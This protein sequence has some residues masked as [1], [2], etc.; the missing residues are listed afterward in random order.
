MSVWDRLGRSLFV[1]CAVGLAWGIRGDFGHMLGAAYPGA[2]L[3][4]AFAYVTGQRSMFRWM[5]IVSAAS[6]LAISQGGRMSYGVLHGYAQADT[7]INYAY[8]LFCLVLEGGAWGCFGGAAIGLLLEPERERLRPVD[9]LGL[10]GT[11]LAFGWATYHVVV[12]LLGFHINPYRSDLS[13]GYTGGVVGLFVWLANHR[14]YYGLRGAASAFLG[15]GLGMAFSRFLA[16]ATH[17]Q[18]YTINHW[19]VMEVGTGFFGGLVFTYSMLGKR[20]DDPPAAEWQ[21]TLSKLSIPFVMAGIPLYH[22]LTRVDVKKKA[23]ELKTQAQAWG[24]GDPAEFARQNVEYLRWVCLL[25]FAGAVVWLYIHARDK[26]R[27]SAFPVLFFSA[28][29]LL[30][31]NVNAYYFWYDRKPNTINMHNVFW[32]LF[33]LMVLYSAVWSK[34]DVTDPDAEADRVPW[35]RWVVG[36]LVAYALTVALTGLVNGERSMKSANTR[37]PIWAWT[38]GPYTG[39]AYGGNPDRR[40]GRRAEGKDKEAKDKAKTGG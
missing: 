2:V 8:G 17:H 35:R 38:Q 30:F 27:L 19:N 15:F 29:M 9:W 31:Q 20:I 11:V 10:A 1:A 24:V 22:L 18:P 26:F 5:P 14:K 28:V 34:R 25:A 13:I 37:W 12:T 4:M 23:A 3:G 39:R 36:G 21:E 32:V 6:A 40:E 7:F 33:G 16:N